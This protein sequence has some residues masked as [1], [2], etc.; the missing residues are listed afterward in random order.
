MTTPSD[1][2]LRNR[3]ETA[4]TNRRCRLRGYEILYLCRYHE[5]TQA[6]TTRSLKTDFDFGN[7]T[8]FEFEAF[9][10]RMSYYD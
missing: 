2:D 4:V 9:K 5:N 7:A 8:P 6:D 3:V 10:R 1:T